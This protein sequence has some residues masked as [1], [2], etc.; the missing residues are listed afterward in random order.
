MM[1]E[2]TKTTQPQ[3]EPTQDSDLEQRLQS[4]DT[5]EQTEETS[6]QAEVKPSPET[7]NLPDLSELD[8]P[9]QQPVQ[10][11]PQAE[12]T[13]LPDTPE[14][15]KFA[16]DF[17]NYLGFDITE[18]RTGVQELQKYRQQVAQ[19]AA[20]AAQ[21]K[22]TASLQQEWGL[23]G[24]AFD[25]R[26]SQIVERFK[27]YSPEMQKRLDN[28]EGAKL[29]W[30]KIQEESKNSDVPQ[31]MKSSPGVSSGGKKPMFTRAE[32]MNMS[33]EQ[34]AKNADRILKAYQLGLV[35]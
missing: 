22:Q 28:V 5:T 17:K 11:Q 9:T 31:F 27:Q 33:K 1:Q 32:I 12:P 18:L 16:E 8:V 15:K 26:M 7:S 10:T 3:A 24:D 25:S 2:E 6:T 20:Q 34:Y 23:Q 19:E 30:A 29:I 21:V 13:A 4:L 14:A 35:Q